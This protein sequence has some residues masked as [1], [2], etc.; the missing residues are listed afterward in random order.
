[1]K[2][3]LGLLALGL[4]FATDVMPTVIREG[5]GMR[6]FSAAQAAE[7]MQKEVIA[8]QI[9]KQGFSCD[10]PLSVERDGE[11][12]KPNKAVWVLKCENATYRVRP[13]PHR[14]ADVER[15]D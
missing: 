10:S 12:L 7:E 14:A 4:G 1:M 11:S 15:I 5:A 6:L 8:A 3:I 2:T 9:R 13:I